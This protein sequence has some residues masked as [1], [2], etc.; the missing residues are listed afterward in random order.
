MVDALLDALPELFRSGRAQH[1][2]LASVVQ[3]SSMALEQA[4]G[5]RAVVFWSGVEPGNAPSKR[6]EELK[7]V[8]TDKE[9]TLLSGRNPAMKAL[10]AECI[11]RFTSVDLF[12]CTSNLGVA[13]DTASLAVLPAL[14][15]AGMF[16]YPAFEVER[17]GERLAN[18]VR[19]VV[20]RPSGYDAIAKVRTS[21]GI[22]VRTI[23]PSTSQLLKKTKT[24]QK[25]EKRK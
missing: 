24:K 22:T 8:G 3:A 16:H 7:V 23:Y 11:S 18:E 4:G 12:L 17:D 20:T 19:R 14:T 9:K 10:A 25:K 2:A 15:G 6:R 13:L 1:S 21:A 5:G